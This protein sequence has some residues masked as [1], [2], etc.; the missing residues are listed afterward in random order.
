[1]T[2]VLFIHGI[3]NQKNSKEDIEREWGKA[4]KQGA[5]AAGLALPHDVQFMAAFY[6]DVLFEETETWGKN[7]TTLTPMS[8]SSLDEDY[9]D[10]EIADLYLEFQKKYNLSDEQVANELDDEDERQQYRRMAG[11]VHKRWLKAIARALE[12]VLPANGAGLV[13]IF[14]GQAAAYLH[15]PGLKERIDDLVKEQLLDGLLPGEEV[16]IIGHSLGT[17]IAYDLLRRLRREVKVKLLLT[18]GS[19][20]GIEIIK[21][22][23]GPPLIC[24]PNVD[25]WVN[26]SDREDFVAL[27]P[28]LTGATFGCDKVVNIDEVDNGHK[29]AH[30]IRKY[31]AHQVVVQVIVSHL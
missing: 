25:T 13:R 29:D 18:A 3:N 5:T 1:M 12:K 19:P 20:L 17:I 24:L 30:D 10:K 11:G 8:A 15:K 9:V 14:L 2:K 6:G 23:L 26:V 27:E 16:V 7:K 28:K 4:I 22:R 31:L 21:H